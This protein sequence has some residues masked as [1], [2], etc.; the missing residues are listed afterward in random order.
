MQ[1]HGGVA[2]QTN[3]SGQ[4]GLAKAGNQRQVSGRLHKFDSDS[5]RKVAEV[6]ES[7]EQ[8]I[9]WRPSESSP[10]VFGAPIPILRGV[11]EPK[12]IVL[13]RASINLFGMDQPKL[14]DDKNKKP[15]P[16]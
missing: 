13:R 2:Y 12:R 5:Q 1:D 15:D 9:G 11:H 16:Q 7:D 6:N 8:R 14:E 10:T 4:A 3:S